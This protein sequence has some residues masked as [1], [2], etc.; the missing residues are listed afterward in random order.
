MT[1]QHQR[2]E[3]SDD[4]RFGVKMMSGRFFQIG[5]GVLSLLLLAILFYLI[6]IGELV[7]LFRGISFGMICYLMLISIALVYVSVIK[8]QVLLEAQGGAEGAF[9]LFRLYLIG[10]FFNLLLPSFVGGDAMRSWYLGKQH[11]QREAAAATFLERY[12]GLFAML[13]LA[14][15]FMWT[16]SVITVPVQITVLG[17]A[18]C[19]LFASVFLL[20]KTA[21]RALASLPTVGQKFAKQGALFQEA[22]ILSAKC[23]KRIGFVLLYSLLFHCLAVVNVMACAHA[24]GWTS[25]PVADVF[26]VLPVILLLSALPITPQGFGIQ[27]GAFVFYLTLLGASSA[28]ALGIAL[29]VRAKAYVLALFGGACWLFEGKHPVVTD[30]TVPEIQ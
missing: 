24:V 27:E 2:R 16:S 18:I 22:V 1:S 5:R 23:P 28:E 15:L 6:P 8:W 7:P 20:S 30:S 25:V 14:C 9:R 29:I 17:I 11:G 4:R 19:F 13:L 3:S 21:V 12:S 10:Y 26:V